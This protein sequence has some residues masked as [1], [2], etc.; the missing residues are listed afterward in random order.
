MA[1][2]L[3]KTNNKKGIYLQ[4]YE[5]FYDPQ[6]GHTAHRSYKPIGYVHELIESGIDDPV[7][8]FQE[9]VLMLNQK[10]NEEKNAAKEKQISEVNPR[11]APWILPS[12]KYK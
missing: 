6:R 8:F 5:S 9:E 3:K 1:Y 10:R 4:I 12:Q 7:S 11:K 2:F